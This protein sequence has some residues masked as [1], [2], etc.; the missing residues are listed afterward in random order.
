MAYNNM[1]DVAYGI[2]R[3]VNQ[4][5]KRARRD[6]DTRE[7]EI[8]DQLVKA[9]KRPMEHHLINISSLMGEKDRLAGTV[10]ELVGS[11][12]E[13]VEKHVPPYHLT[14]N[15]PDEIPMESIYLQ[16][17]SLSNYILLSA[18]L[19]GVLEGIL[20]EK[21]LDDP[22]IKSNSKTLIIN[23]CELEKGSVTE[24]KWESLSDTKDPGGMIYCTYGQLLVYY[25]EIA[26][27]F[28]RTFQPDADTYLDRANEILDKINEL[29]PDTDKCFRDT[30]ELLFDASEL[31]KRASRWI[32][33]M[34]D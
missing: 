20:N 28:K 15:Q 13:C 32:P 24:K 19:T 30:S 25:P 16:G 8:I 14:V 33:T 31:V 9:E 29:S 5:I 27:E 7:Q 34:C 1:A 26:P 23:A 18:L 22:E 3:I 2:T 10:V 4:M 11:I 12:G 17:K 6:L 21:L